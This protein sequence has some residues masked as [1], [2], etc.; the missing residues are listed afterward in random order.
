MAED[1]YY[2]ILGVGK[3]ASEEE[4]RKAYKKLALIHH[5]DKNGGDD[6]MFKKINTAHDTLIN[7]EKRHIYDNPEPDFDGEVNPFEMFFR[8][9]PGMHFAQ[10]SG[11]IRRNNVI[12]R[13]NVKLRDIHTGLTKTLKIKLNKICF[14]CKQK[15]SSCKGS[16]IE[17][18]IIKNG[19]FIQQVQSPCKVCNASGSTNKINPACGIC[20]GAG[21]YQIND[22]IVVNIPKGANADYKIIFR[23]KGEQEQN[24]GEIP[25]DF[26]VALQIEDDP[27]FKREADNLIYTTRLTLAESFIGKDISVPHYDE[28]ITVNTNIFGIINPNNRYFIKGKGLCGRGDLI[29]VFEIVYPAKILNSS[30]RESLSGVFTSIGIN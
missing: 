25:G 21:N 12:Y 27:Y 8:D 9:M 15:C 18:K 23:K 6:T 3:D 4:I 26:I 20:K 28:N 10:K 24:P 11:P 5:P 16:G 14:D 7:P 13:I 22:T 1:N 2:D 29:F 19:P 30:E 17:V